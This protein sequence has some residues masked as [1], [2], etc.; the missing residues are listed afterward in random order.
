MDKGHTSDSIDKRIDRF[1]SKKALQ[2]PSLGLAVMHPKVV[3]STL[4]PLH[5]VLAD[6]LLAKGG[7]G[8][9]P[10]LLSLLS[11]YPVSYGRRTVHS[12]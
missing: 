1:L 11:S 10:Y 7:K 2:H 12:S 4:K 3:E 6:Q 9:A 8:L 5:E